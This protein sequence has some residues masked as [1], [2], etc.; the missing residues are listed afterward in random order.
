MAMESIKDAHSGLQPTIDTSFDKHRQGLYD[1]N[2]KRLDA[3]TDCAVSYGKQ[4]IP[5]RGH[6]DA[7]SSSKS[8]NKGNFKAIL[9]F[10]ALGDSILQNI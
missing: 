5:F 4:N 7:N 3:I 2:C 10:R 8:L 9:E 1:L 6:L